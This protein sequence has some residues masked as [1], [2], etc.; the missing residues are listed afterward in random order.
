ML[1]FIR[2]DEYLPGNGIFS[3]TGSFL[4]G[5]GARR[6]QR[7]QPSLRALPAP[8]LQ[9]LFLPL[10][11]FIPTFS[12][13]GRERAPTPDVSTGGRRSELRACG[14]TPPRAKCATWK[15]ALNT[16]LRLRMSSWPSP[17]VKD[18]PIQLC[19]YGFHSQKCYLNLF[20]LSLFFWGGL[21]CCKVSQSTWYLWHAS[22]E[23][24][25]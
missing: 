21:K 14:P 24:K 1:T 16:L 3:W 12:L 6:E 13:P 25:I 19:F 17:V 20:S 10:Y 2:Y 4:A 15:R 8:F 18:G 7:R 11:V 9:Q 22:S 23:L 5:N